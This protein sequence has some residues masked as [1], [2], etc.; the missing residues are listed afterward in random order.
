MSITCLDK[1]TIEDDNEIAPQMKKMKL[2]SAQIQV[3]EILKPELINQNPREH[4][5]MIFPFCSDE[6][7]LFFYSVKIRKLMK[8]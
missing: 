6:V 3:G 5:K 7:N 1:M 8:F 4:L 2:N